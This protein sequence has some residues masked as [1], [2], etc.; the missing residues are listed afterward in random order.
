MEKASYLLKW[1]GLEKKQED[2]KSKQERQLKNLEECRRQGALRQVQA[3]ETKLRKQQYEKELRTQSEALLT[4]KGRQELQAR[5]SQSLQ[6]RLK[7][8]HQR[9]KKLKQEREDLALARQTRQT[10]LVEI[11]RKREQL[12]I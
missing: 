10:M 1:Q 8:A 11:S 12:E 9:E 2:M 3:Q 7:E 4:M 5:E 6:Q